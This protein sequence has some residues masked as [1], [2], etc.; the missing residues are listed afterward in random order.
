MTSDGINF[1]I[2]HWLLAVG[3][4]TIRIL[5]LR[6]YTILYSLIG[7]A[8]PYPLESRVLPISIRLQLRSVWYSML[9]DSMRNAYRPL[10]LSTRSTPSWLLF[11][12]TVGLDDSITLHILWY[13]LKFDLCRM[14]IERHYL[15]SWFFFLLLKYF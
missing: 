10:P 8:M 11:V 12:N 2:L 6:L 3:T 14:Y 15:Y 7:I 13:K 9:D 4:Y 1:K 5:F